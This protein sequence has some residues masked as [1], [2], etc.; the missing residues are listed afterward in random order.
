MVLN[1]TVDRGKTKWNV[2]Q[3]C[4]SIHACRRVTGFS[5]LAPVYPEARREQL[6]DVSIRTHPFAEEPY[7]GLDMVCFVILRGLKGKRRANMA[8]V[9]GRAS[10]ACHCAHSAG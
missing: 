2:G 8:G 1:L 4:L 3:E 7:A 6:L 5:S 9:A 10:P